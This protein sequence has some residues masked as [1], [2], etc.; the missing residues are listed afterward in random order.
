TDELFFTHYIPKR[1]GAESLLD[2]IDFACGTREKY[3]ELP[4]GTH[5]IQLP[6]PA[7]SS[8]FLDTFGRPQRVIACECERS[9]E[10]N[11]SQTLRM[12]NGD[13]INRKV[14]DGN[15]RIP[16][17]IAAGKTDDAILTEIYQV[18]LGRTPNRLERA[19]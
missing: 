15:G 10:P 19:Q 16:I 7:V 18:T 6:D 3:P 13:I 9:S 1:L 11:L 4:L 14:T 17:L 2:S 8:D 5:A 12:M